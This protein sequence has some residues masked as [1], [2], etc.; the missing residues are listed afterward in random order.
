[1]SSLSHSGADVSFPLWDDEPIDGAFTMNSTDGLDNAVVSGVTRPWLFG[2]KP[3]SENAHRRP[4]LVIGGGGY[5]ELMV[6]REGIQ[7]AKWLNSLGFYAFVLIHRFPNSETG[8][9]APIDDARRALRIIDEKGFAGK[10]VALCGLS[11]GGHLAASLLASYPS[12]WTERIQP[13]SSSPDLPKISFALIGYA[14]ISTNAVGRQIIANKPALPPAEKQALYNAVQPDVQLI[15]PAPPTFIVYAG[16]DPVVP[17][18]NAYRLAEGLGKAGGQVEL[19]VFGDAPHGFGVDT[20]GQPVEKWTEM[21]QAWIE[22]GG[23]LG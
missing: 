22:Q 7:V 11:S 8:A 5:V 17:V 21:A 3:T 18:V 13:T 10:G 16:N 2:Y 19:H 15:S 4:I 14:P 12:S 20:K 1:M 23:F 9:Q 6:G